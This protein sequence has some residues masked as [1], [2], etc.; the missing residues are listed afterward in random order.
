M[1]PKGKIK[2]GTELLGWVGNINIWSSTGFQPFL[3]HGIVGAMAEA[4]RKSKGAPF[5]EKSF[6]SV[7]RTLISHN[8]YDVSPGQVCKFLSLVPSDVLD[9]E[10]FWEGFRIW[11]CYSGWWEENEPS[12]EELDEWREEMGLE[13]IHT[14]MFTGE[15]TVVFRRM[16]HCAPPEEIA[17]YRIA[18]LHEL[19]QVGLTSENVENFPER[20]GVLIKEN[21]KWRL[22]RPDLPPKLYTTSEPGLA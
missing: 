13:R 15:L 18:T 16:E 20:R 19:E 5:P 3:G 7:G 17:G 8:G 10:D 4:V 12:W 21:D 14:V 11:S 1:E 22:V 6:E 2:L 9:K